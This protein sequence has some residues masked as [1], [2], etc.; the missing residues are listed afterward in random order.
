[1]KKIRLF[2][3]SKCELSESPMWN[4]REKMLYWRGFHGEIYRKPI[5]DNPAD[6]ECF[7]LNIGIIGSM[8]FTDSD[9][10]LLFAEGGKI[11]KWKPG[12]EPILY[13]DFG[14]S[15]FNDVIVDK[16]GRI[17]CGMLAEN[18]FDVEKRGKHGKFYLFENGKLTLIEE[19]KGVT[20]NGI[21]ISPDNKKLYFGITDEGCVH[22][23]SYDADSGKLSD[24]RVF[25]TDC[26]PDGMT[27]DKDGNL[28]V[29]NCMPGKSLLCYNPDGEL[30]DQIFIDTYRLISVAF[31][32]EN[33]DLL[34]IT[35]ACENEIADGKCGGV[36]V[37]ENAGVGAD[38]Y[39]LKEND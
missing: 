15:L 24:K 10:M 25:A 13:K 23:Y 12:D 38:E 21:R 18:Y 2:A 27:I 1:M 28:W 26:C 39:I 33:N 35:T 8:V 22:V 30:I 4:K 19:T 32:G 17:Y 37:V 29:V 34:F 9:Y 11:W 36:Y 31:G 3:D 14:L 7:K 16:C 20:P 5:D 6:F